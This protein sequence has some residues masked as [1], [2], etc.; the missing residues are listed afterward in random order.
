MRILREKELPCVKT[1]TLEENLVEKTCIP[2][3]SIKHVF[4]E[5]STKP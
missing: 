5:P 2:F 1:A 3:R 4:I